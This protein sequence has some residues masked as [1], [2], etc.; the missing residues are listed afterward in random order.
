MTRVGTRSRWT[1]N[2]RQGTRRTRTG[3]GPRGLG[4]G[5]DIEGL[6]LKLNWTRR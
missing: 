1:T 3:L 6:G 5:V 2:L 4:L